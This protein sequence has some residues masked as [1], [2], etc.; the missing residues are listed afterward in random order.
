MR[1]GLDGERLRG[2]RP[3]FMGAQRAA[4]GVRL[5]AARMAQIEA[6]FIQLKAAEWL[7]AQP[8]LPAWT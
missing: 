7:L 8:P 3:H 5:E 2:A 4:R 6:F 1:E